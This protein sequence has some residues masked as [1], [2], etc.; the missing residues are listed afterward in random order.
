MSLWHEGKPQVYGTQLQLVN[1]EFTAGEIEDE[2]RVDERRA[3]I[4]Q[5][6]LAEYIAATKPFYTKT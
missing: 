5:G 2:T 1:G 3:R 4:G 6:P